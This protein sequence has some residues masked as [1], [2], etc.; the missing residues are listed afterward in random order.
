MRYLNLQLYIFFLNE[1][2]IKVSKKKR[3]A[4][5]GQISP[6]QRTRNLMLPMGNIKRRTTNYLV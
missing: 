5:T 2:I 3:D 6:R 4:L 1:F